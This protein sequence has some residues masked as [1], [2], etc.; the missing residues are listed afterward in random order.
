MNKERR[1]RLHVRLD[2]RG[3][4]FQTEG[5]EAMAQAA[6]RGCRC[7]LPT[8]ESGKD[9][10]LPLIGDCWKATKI[11]L[12]I[13]VVEFLFLKL[14]HTAFYLG[15]KLRALLASLLLLIQTCCFLQ[16]QKDVCLNTCVSL[17]CP[18][19]AE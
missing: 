3:K 19:Q 17:P 5:G 6:Q 4:L 13:T 12:C 11:V 9:K 1:I 7:E 14:S 10:N 18:S 16:D 8:V 2:T 15:N